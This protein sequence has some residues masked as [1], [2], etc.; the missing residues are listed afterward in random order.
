MTSLSFL[1]IDPEMYEWSLSSSHLGNHAMHPLAS[2][3][4]TIAA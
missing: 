4:I 3:V 1:S 2:K